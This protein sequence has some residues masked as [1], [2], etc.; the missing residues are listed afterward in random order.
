MKIEKVGRGR[1]IGEKENVERGRSGMLVECLRR[2]PCSPFS[3]LLC[4]SP[5]LRRR[6][7][8][9]SYSTWVIPM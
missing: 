5:S 4:F 8:E 7:W 9:G 2:R 3:F 1:A 6:Q